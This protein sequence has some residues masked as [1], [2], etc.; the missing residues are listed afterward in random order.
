V[1]RFWTR[2]AEGLSRRP[3]VTFAVVLLAIVA[4]A[5]GLPKLE[6]ATGQE[7]YLNRDEQ[8]FVDNEHYQEAFGGAAMLVLFEGPVTELFTQPNLDRMRAMEQELRDT[9]QAETV[10]GP[11]DGLEFTAN[12][13]TMT[14]AGEPTDDPTQ[15]VA[16]GMLLRAIEREQDP[17][18]KAARQ[19]DLLATAGRLAEA[20]EHDL[21]NPA[22]VEFLLFGNDGGIRQPLLPFFPD[23]EH[24]QMVVRLP[25]NASIEVEGAA[26]SAVEDVVAKYEF[27]GFEITT[28]GAPVLLKGIND[29]LKGGMATLG[30]IAVAIMVLVL[31][32]VFRVRWRLLSLAVVAV[33]AVWAFGLLG[34]LGVPLSLVTISGLPIIVGMGADFAIITHS[35]V[36]EEA[37][38][39]HH[40]HPMVRT[41]VNLAP[42]LLVAVVAAVLAALALQLSKVPMI[43]EFGVMLAIGLSLLWVAAV[44][45]VTTVLSI[46]ERRRPTPT[47]PEISGHT[48]LERGV[49]RAGSMPQRLVP[50]FMVLSVALF[51]TGVLFED[52]FEIQTDPE[53]WVDQES[54]VVKDLEHLREEIGSSSELGVLVEGDVL[55]D[56]SGEFV[57]QYAEDQM[58][59]EPA[60]QTVSS[61]PTIVA[62]TTEAPPT[63]QDLEEVLAVA[64]DDVRRSLVSEDG[65]SMNVIFLIGRTTLEE[66]AELVDRMQS[67]LTAPEGLRA[68][69]SGLAMVGVGLLNNLKEN[70]ALLTY[71]ALGLVVAWLLVRYRNLTRVLLPLVP[72]LIAVGLTSLVVALSG[73]ELSPLTTVSGPLVIANCTEFSVLIMGRYLEE[74]GRGRSVGEAH[75]VAAARTGRAFVASA[76]T[77]VGGFGVLAFS[78]LP[79]LRDFG[80]IVALN[81]TVALA[82]ALVVLPPLLMW[83]DERGLLLRAEREPVATPTPAGAS[84]R[85]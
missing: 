39:E 11:L 9:G 73:I 44:V 29:Y 30:G 61:L 54:Q 46:R 75:D 58:A 43:R 48:R 24:G 35:R 16:G 53:K 66:R 77:A 85:A 21:A 70:R 74:R 22:W 49:V 40:D 17:D 13:V 8:I 50:V 78:S 4:L 76:L 72:V 36:E 32:L 27:E 26:A 38:V 65:Q 55:S 56:E 34:Y 42:P 80:I 68:T 45:I 37:G 84:A 3:S 81:V 20:G 19:E 82:S 5:L 52:N 69:P 28:T 23:E 79:L 1:R 71:A 60:L 10:V 2:V 18:R 59:A 31:L 63:A 12:Q 51:A 83:A 25:G 7:S 47:S 6:F 67:R 64:P 41:L 62:Q 15:T 14:G 33:G 57:A